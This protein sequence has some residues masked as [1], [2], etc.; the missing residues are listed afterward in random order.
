[1][2][3]VDFQVAVIFF[4]QHHLC[5][6]RFQP[7]PCFF[8][9]FFF[10]KE[11]VTL[12]FC[13]SSLLQKLFHVFVIHIQSSES[14]ASAV[15]PGGETVRWGGEWLG[16][17]E[18]LRCWLECVLPRTIKVGGFGGGKRPTLEE[19]RKLNEPGDRFTCD[20][21]IWVDDG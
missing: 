4:L 13:R 14:Q 11:F 16:I 17:M 6:L 1:M 15:E 20:V 12:W 3:D 2:L 18:C 5:V 8:R 19:L 7:L 10:P 9:M 21:G